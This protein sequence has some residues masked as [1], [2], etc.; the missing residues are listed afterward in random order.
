MRQK[1]NT[2]DESIIIP[3][4]EAWKIIKEVKD[5]NS[6]EAWLKYSEDLEQFHKRL[7]KANTPHEFAF[8]KHLYHVIDEAG[9]VI[10]ALQSQEDK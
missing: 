2:L 5:N 4:N 3:Y 9:E 1:T 7:S 8:L 6:D 10:G